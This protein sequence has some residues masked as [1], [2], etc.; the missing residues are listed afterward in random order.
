MSAE[1]FVSHKVFMAWE[2]EQEEIYLNEM[3][4]KGWQV[5]EGGCFHTVFEKIPGRQFCYRLDYNPKAMKDPEERERYIETFAADGWEFINNTFNGWIYLRKERKEGMEEE[6][7]EI[8]S[9]SSSL[10]ELFARF[11]R[12]LLACCIMALAALCLEISLLISSSNLL[13]LVFVLLLLGL[14]LWLL[15]GK[16][17]LKKVRQG[18]LE[19]N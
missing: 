11:D 3:S 19:K 12:M 7:F 4:K 8:Y 6:D 18:L 2:Y 14:L 13:I 5:T 17:R 10:G 9:D 1:R 16:S 15:Q